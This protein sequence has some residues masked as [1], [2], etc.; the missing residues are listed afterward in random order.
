[1]LTWQAFGPGK[2]LNTFKDALY[3]R[4]F[5]ITA[6]VFLR[7]LPQSLDQTLSKRKRPRLPA[8]GDA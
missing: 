7:L 3:S 4:D 6:E 2:L 1:M 8:A 5:A